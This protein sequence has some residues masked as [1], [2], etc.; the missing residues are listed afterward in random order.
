MAK[1][2]NIVGVAFFAMAVVMTG[3]N[4]IIALHLHAD[5]F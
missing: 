4:A 5:S 2:L 1:N 3:W